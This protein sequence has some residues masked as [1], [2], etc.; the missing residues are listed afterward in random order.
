MSEG[1]FPSPAVALDSCMSALLLNPSRLGLATFVI[2][3]CVSTTELASQRIGSRSVG[4]PSADQAIYPRRLQVK[5]A[6][7][8]GALWNAGGLVSRTGIELGSVA[9]I[10]AKAKSVEHCFRLPMRDLDRLHE[11][12]VRNLGVGAAPVAH[13]GLWFELKT[14]GA[15]ASERL[16][17]DL[18]ANEWVRHAGY[19]HVLYTASV[20]SASTFLSAGD[21]P[22]TTPLFASRQLYV[23]PAPLGLGASFSRRVLG[24]RGQAGL[25]AYH[26]ER[27]WLADHEDLSKISPSQFVS[28]VSFGT[29]PE[30]NH[31]TA[32]V[33][34][35]ASDRNGY[36]VTGMADAVAFRMVASTGI[37]DL[38][39]AIAMVA[40]DARPGDVAVMILQLLIHNS[41]P[42]DF[43]PG[44]YL[45]IYFDAI[46]TVTASGVVFITA[47]GNGDNDLDDPRF[48]R[49]FDRSFRD[50]GAI[51]VAATDGASQK[52]ADFSNYGSIIDANGWGHDVVTTGY[53]T[54]FR[55]L[56]DHRQFYTENYSGT[57]AASATACGAVISWLSAA[58]YQTGKVLLPP[59][60]RSR[61]RAVGTP[62]SGGIGF[63]VDAEQLLAGD[64]LPDGVFAAKGEVDVGESFDVYLSGAV[65]DTVILALGFAELSTA[66]GLNRPF[67][68]DPATLVT[69]TSATLTAGTT[70]GEATVLLTVPNDPGLKDMDLFFQGLR[71]G[72]N[73][74]LDVTSSSEVW[75]R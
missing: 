47:A 62:V 16:L 20:P 71:I 41:K 75:I 38:A 43:V 34:V 19:A 69:V 67:H 70:G 74:T 49:L 56:A 51:M 17:E 23:G 45:Q 52:K 25:R 12:A 24:G 4:Q 64:G 7:G 15:K 36:G 33:G 50:S 5:L 53:G 54:M 40:L 21:I 22:P 59:E 35:L 31:A 11:R 27:N 73:Q 18:R 57:S 48:H 72:Q 6:E 1:L 3:L 65:G 30:T 58:R 10:F 46:R 60:V 32:V 37:G 29:G 61:L 13:L 2:C 39:T 26:V 8:S 14:T 68:L 9:E 63:R 55:P 44:E 42:N 66:L 28:G